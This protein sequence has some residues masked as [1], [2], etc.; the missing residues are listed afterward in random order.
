MDYIMPEISALVPYACHKSDLGRFVTEAAPGKKELFPRTD[1][2][3]D[4]DRIIHSS[5]FLRLRNK[6][7]VFVYHE[8]DSFRTRLTHSLEVAQIARTIAR[9]L[10]L[11]EDIAE[12]VAL[13][14]DLGHPPFGHA[15]EQAMNKV[16]VPFGGFDHNEQSVRVLTLLEEKYADFDGLNL[17]G[18]TLEGVVKHNGPLINKSDKHAELRPTIA[19]LNSKWD[20]KL[21]LYAPAEAQVANMSDDIAYLAHD[22][23]DGLRAGLLQLH[24]LEGLPVVGDILS[25]LHNRY[26]NCAQT[27][28]VHEL[29]RRL[30][31]HFVQDILNESV[32]VLTVLNP[33]SVDDIRS[34]GR[35]VIC[36]STAAA[37]ALS[38]LRAFLFKYSWRHFKVNRMT[39]K[40][41]HLLTELFERLLEEPNLLPTEWQTA[42]ENKGEVQQARII[43]DYVASMTD[44]YA[45]LEYERIFEPG[46]ILS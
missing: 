38:Q 40:S 19:T 17:T 32:S 34:A 13:A 42:L 44:R 15:G 27:R 37:D 43:A 41:K 26:P 25:E 29:S 5:A 28:L 39:S 12:A 36:H 31:S 21:D 6:T 1:F 14:H 16:M 18:E 20:L 33:Q 8:G 23:N 24:Q 11:N 3:R 4:R 10:S 2:Q 35:A 22:F 9:A 30:I 7:Q 46:P 45:L